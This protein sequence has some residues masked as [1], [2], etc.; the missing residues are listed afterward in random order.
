MKTC[1][2]H[3]STELLTLKKIHIHKIMLFYLVDEDPAVGV[4]A[5]LGEHVDVELG[6]GAAQAVAGA[7]CT[8]VVTRVHRAQ[9]LLRRFHPKQHKYV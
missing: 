6:G 7:R 8:P 4:R 3:I 1:N 5:L 9:E 2:V